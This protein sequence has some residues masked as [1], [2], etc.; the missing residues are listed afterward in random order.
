MST[1]TMIGV[2]TTS[3]AFIIVISLV[4]ICVIF[5]EINS[6]HNNVMDEMSIFRTIAD[7][8]WERMV[9][10]HSGP[11]GHRQETFSSLISRNKRQVFVPPAHCQ[12]EAPDLCPPGP[13]GPPG[14]KGLKGFDGPPGRDG[15]DGAP[16]VSLL[17]TYHFPGGC[18]ECP[19][20]QPGPPGPDGLEGD[21]GETGRRGPP[22]ERGRKG[23]NGPSGS[24]GEMGDPGLD[25]EPGRPG[26]PGR[27]G[28]RGT[29]TPGPKG[30]T[31]PRG[32]PGEPGPNGERGADGEPGEPGPDGRPGNDGRKGNDGRP[33]PPGSPGLPG[34]DAHYCPCP[35]RSAAY[36]A[37]QLSESQHQPS[38]E[39]NLPPRMFQ[40]HPYRQ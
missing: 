18:I 34:P 15:R 17:A 33:G 30:P 11:G 31:G 24:P 37:R 29:G 1:Q 38:Q 16:G 6:L 39:F 28:R 4:A 23:S 12:C 14:D 19:P 25:G 13:T 20:G 27:D 35:A 36:L 5:N 22:G 2:A 9:I 10:M 40:S 32:L 8:T 26:P 21:Y 3:C 7:D